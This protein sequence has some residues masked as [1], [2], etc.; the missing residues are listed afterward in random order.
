VPIKLANN[1]FEHLGRAN[2][3]YSN[4]I[5]ALN[6]TLL[7]YANPGTID[8]SNQAKADYLGLINAVKT[9][10]V[11][12]ALSYFDRDYMVNHELYRN[13]F[14]VKHD[15]CL[16]NLQMLYNVKTRKFYP[17]VRS[18]GDLNSITFNYGTFLPSYNEYKFG[19]KK[20]DI[21]A[22]LFRIINQDPHFRIAKLNRQ[23]ELLKTL[24]TLKIELQAAYEKH[25]EA[26]MYDAND[27]YSIREKKLLFPKQLNT[28][29]T[30]LEL[31]KNA[32]DNAILYTNCIRDGDSIIFEFMADSE[33]PIKI[34]SMQVY[35]KGQSKKTYAVT[36]K[37]PHDNLTIC[38]YDPNLNLI[39]TKKHMI[40]SCSDSLTI[41][42]VIVFARNYITG[43]KLE[44]NKNNVGYVELDSPDRK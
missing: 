20:T 35:Y 6:E 5:A 9:D 27:Y 32:L 14:G 11:V 16:G 2:Q 28:L 31:M 17:V 34:D 39:P 8:Y 38:S 26:F 37:L 29:F 12:K 19:N 25:A 24:D 15:V 41:D 44:L 3:M 18:E 1:F 13:M 10:S 33:I 4:E 21:Y 40:F 43:S 22:H 30:N 42:K 7:T 36:S 23:Y